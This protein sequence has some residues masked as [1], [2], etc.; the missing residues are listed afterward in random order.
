MP[1]RANIGAQPVTRAAEP[2][3]LARGQRVAACLIVLAS[4]IDIMGSTS[5]FAAGTAIESAIGL[6]QVGLQ[7]AFTATS[8]PAGALLLVGGRLADLYLYGRRRMFRIGLG[9]L[10]VSSLAGGL[11]RSV[12]ELLAARVAQGVA[13]AL[14]LPAALSLLLNLF[15]TARGRT[16]ALATRS[17]IGGVGATVGLV[18]GGLVT[19]GL[20]W[21]WVFWLNVPLGLIVLGASPYVLREAP[22][23]GTSRALDLA[24][25]VT[26]TAAL[27][28]LIYAITQAPAQGWLSMKTVGLLVLALTLSA[29]FVCI[30]SRSDHAMIPPRLLRAGTVLRGNVVLFTAGMS[31]D[32][33]L[34]TLTL[35]T[36]RSLGFSALQFGLITAVMTLGSVG[37]AYAAERAIASLGTDRIANIG[38]GL[39]GVTCL[40]FAATVRWGGSVVPLTVGMLL[41][42]AGMGCAYVAGS[43]ASLHGVPHHESGIAAGIQNVAFTLGTILG[44]AVFST[45]SAAQTQR[46]IAAGSGPVPATRGGLEAAF[47]IGAVVAACGLVAVVLSPADPASSTQGG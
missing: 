43:I 20:G 38:L 25:I 15:A 9:L 2:A 27:A 30:E 32:G 11:A 37:T 4:F 8:L 12:G 22:R 40:C 42:G 35:Y 14:L 47:T 29:I 24:G 5:V 34:F 46:L 16:K 26:S 18:L 41:F 7:W 28:G 23:A 3:R 45:V 17:A 19:A 44:V 39:L 36:Q 31:V 13:G 1:Q 6:T 21:P 10:V 33:L